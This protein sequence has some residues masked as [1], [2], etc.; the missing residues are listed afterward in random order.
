MV[1]TQKDVHFGTQCLGLDVPLPLLHPSRYR[2]QRTTRGQ[3]IWLGFRRKTLSFSTSNRFI[4]ALS[5]LVL[6]RFVGTHSR[7]RSQSF[8]DNVE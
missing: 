2:D 3:R 1:G 6:R 5:V 4:P 7:T 8:P